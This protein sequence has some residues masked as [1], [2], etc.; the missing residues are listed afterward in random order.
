MFILV[1]LIGS[2]IFSNSVCFV[3]FHPTTFCCVLPFAYNGGVRF[4]KKRNKHLPLGTY[5]VTTIRHACNC[6]HV[7][8]SDNV[9]NYNM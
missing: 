3:S 7:F 1:K 4:V 8:Y 9:I 5:C 2:F 6:E